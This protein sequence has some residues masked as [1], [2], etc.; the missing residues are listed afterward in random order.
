VVLAGDTPIR[1]SHAGHAFDQRALTLTTG[2]AFMAVRSVD[3]LLNDV[4]DAF[5]LARYER[6]PVVLSVPEDL[7]AQPY[8]YPPDYAPST[9]LMPARQRPMPDPDIV[10][11]V[12]DLVAGA[13]RPVIIAGKGAV[14]SG[15]RQAI[16]AL[17]EAT[18]ALLA[19]SLL[20]KDMFDG[21]AFNIGIAGAFATNLAR[22]LF[23][24]ADLVVGV[25]SSLGYHT[26]EGGYL[27]S[28]ARVVQIDL[29]PRGLWQ[30]GRVAD[31]HMQADAARGVGAVVE[32]L[33]AR[34]IGREG[35]MGMSFGGGW[36]GRWWMGASM[37]W[38]RG[39]WI[40]GG[41]WRR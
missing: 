2:A 31:L 34:R 17:A 36:R 30:G 15:A 18:G 25:G 21:H 33:A 24:E 37:R 32:A 10:A 8:P 35:G 38:G 6:R 28:G 4:R 39:C 13:E 27:Y 20:A 29:T 5:Y 41:W 23:A 7:Q 22:E 26:T 14:A 9:E 16:E 1:A 19:T 11:R 40:R 12:A 3:R